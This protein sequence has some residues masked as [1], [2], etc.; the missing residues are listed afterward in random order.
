MEEAALWEEVVEGNREAFDQVYLQ[1]STPVRSFV[2]HYLQDPGAADDLV[3]ETFLELW[4]K[5]N[6]FNPERGTLKQY[7]FGIARKRAA[8]WRRKSP[9]DA[10]PEIPEGTLDHTADQT[11]FRKALQQLDKDQRAL[12]WLREVEGYSYAELAEIL[13]VPVGTVK[14]R[15]FFAREALR[16]MWLG[17]RKR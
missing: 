10:V 3:Q 8:Q 11:L 13:E 16:R 7:L 15:L 12:L 9:P 4:K 6:G 14:S 17:G 2:R 1:Y 5:P